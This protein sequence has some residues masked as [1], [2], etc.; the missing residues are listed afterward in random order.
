MRERGGAGEVMKHVELVDHFG[1]YQVRVWR[2]N[3]GRYGFQVLEP[4]KRKVNWNKPKW[5][6]VSWGGADARTFVHL[7][8]MFGG[9]SSTAPNYYDHANTL[10]SRLREKLASVGGLVAK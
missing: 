3:S 2:D 10:L 6:S 4:D 8:R 7:S 5:C 1:H 9:C